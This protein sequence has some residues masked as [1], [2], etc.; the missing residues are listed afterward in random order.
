MPLRRVVHALA[1]IHCVPQIQKRCPAYRL[2]KGVAAPDLSRLSTQS[3]VI[4]GCEDS[5]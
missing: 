1:Q 4:N 3:K 5:G 2:A